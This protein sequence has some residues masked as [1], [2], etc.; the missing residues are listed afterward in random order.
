MSNEK[1]ISNMIITS[2]KM[3]QIE[4]GEG[5][6][7]RRYRTAMSNGESRVIIEQNIPND[8]ANGEKIS[9]SLKQNQK[10]LIEF[11]EVENG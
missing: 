6:V 8:L 5:Q 1:K 9:L 3:I 2:K 4:K 7:E 11:K 10:T